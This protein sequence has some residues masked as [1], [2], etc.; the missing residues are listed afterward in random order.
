MSRFMWRV[1]EG[2]DTH[3][4]PPIFARRTDGTYGMRLPRMTILS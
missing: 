4:R 2:D 1:A 3:R